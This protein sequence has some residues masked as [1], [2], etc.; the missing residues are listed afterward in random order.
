MNTSP[1][2]VA[3]ACE[4]VVPL[5]CHAWAAHSHEVSLSARQHVRPLPDAFSSLSPHAPHRAQAYHVEMQLLRA[6]N[7]FWR[8]PEAQRQVSQVRR[9]AK[10]AHAA[11]QV[12]VNTFESCGSARSGARPAPFLVKLGQMVD[13]PRFDAMICW[14]ADGQRIHLR[15]LPAFCAD[16]RGTVSQQIQMQ[17]GVP[18]HHIYRFYHNFSSMA[19]S[20]RFCGS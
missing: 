1:V 20:H 19:S 4:A 15:D 17:E 8:V 5:R 14:T 10:S 13:D 12:A 9:E 18:H 3:A 6:C 16:V 11:F 7:V 2:L